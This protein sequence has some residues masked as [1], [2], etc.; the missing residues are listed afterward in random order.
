M[1][2][3][4]TLIGNLGRDP[5]TRTLQTGTVLTKFSLATSRSY[6]DK[7]GEWQQDTQWHDISAWGNAAER[8]AKLRKGQTVY[9]EGELTYNE[10]EDKNGSKQRRAEVRASYFR[11]ISKND[12]P[13][14]KAAAVVDNGLTGGPE[15]EKGPDGD[16]PF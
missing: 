3:K 7:S 15:M 13:L 10:Y 4:V 5:E 11:I 12:A 14:E 9:V 1:I 6:R 8:A 2:N 16:L